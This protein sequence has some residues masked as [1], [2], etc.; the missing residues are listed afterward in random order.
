MSHVHATTVHRHTLREEVRRD[1]P[2]VRPS[3]VCHYHVLHHKY[4]LRDMACVRRERHA[5][6]EQRVALS[7]SVERA[8]QARAAARACDI[9]GA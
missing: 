6:C 9:G 8:V 1:I 7:R 3:I 2:C 4:A 5:A